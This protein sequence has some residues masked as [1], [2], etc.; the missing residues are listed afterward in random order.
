[1]L[2]YRDTTAMKRSAI[3]ILSGTEYLGFVD[4]VSRSIV[5][6]IKEVYE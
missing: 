5:G 6:D 3:C 4:G 2:A 1:M